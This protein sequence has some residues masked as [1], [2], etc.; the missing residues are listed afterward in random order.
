MAG[1]AFQGLGAPLDSSRSCLQQ[2][3]CA[4]AGKDRVRGQPPGPGQDGSEV[5][6]GKLKLESEYWLPGG[7]ILEMCVFGGRSHACTVPGL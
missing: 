4:V 7:Q 3:S 2:S 5:S 1:K 6:T